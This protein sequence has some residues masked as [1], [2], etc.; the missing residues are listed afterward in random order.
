MKNMITKK[1]IRD[2]LKKGLVEII[3][4]NG[5]YGCYGIVC[6]ICDNAF[7]FAGSEA[8]E[9]TLDEYLKEYSRDD[10]VD[11][12]TYYLNKDGGLRSE[13]P[14]EYLLYYLYLKE[15]LKEVAA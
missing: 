13:F 3:D 5:E 11:Q 10:L 1:M 15:N 12:I 2:G 8:E 7:Y 14:D 9:M 6:K 4:A